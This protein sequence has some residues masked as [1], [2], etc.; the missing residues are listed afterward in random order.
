VKSI[1]NER[2]TYNS[3]DGILTQFLVLY[4]SLFLGKSFVG[5]RSGIQ[6][7]DHTNYVADPNALAKTELGQKMQTEGN[8]AM[9]ITNIRDVKKKVKKSS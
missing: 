4:H 8:L 1:A 2:C 9:P 5:T 6:S 7:D 3:N